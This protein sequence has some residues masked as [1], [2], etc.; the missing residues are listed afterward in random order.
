[1]Q[2]L[3][4]PFAA[5]RGVSSETQKRCCL[6]VFQSIAEETSPETVRLLWEAACARMQQSHTNNAEPDCQVSAP[7]HIFMCM[8]PS[9]CESQMY[10][11]EQ[12]GS[13]H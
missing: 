1:M 11:E 7:G 5:G 4:Q 3:E 8:S 6:K 2:S 10:V 12:C 13:A 9:A